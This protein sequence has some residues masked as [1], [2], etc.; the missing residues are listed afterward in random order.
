M[1]SH[2]RDAALAADAWC[3]H[4]EDSKRIRVLRVIARLNIGG[5][6][7]HATLLTERLD[8]SR[9]DSLLV[10]GTEEPSEGNYLELQG[11]SLDRLVVL[12]VLGREIR[13]L[14]DVIALGR[15]IALMRRGRP[16][17]VHTHTAKAGTLARLAAYLTGVPVILHTYHG[18]VF[19]GYF[20]PARTRVFLSIERWLAKCTDR[21]LTVSATV[22]ED[23]L[24]LRVGR[25]DQLEVVPLG[26][27]LGRFLDCEGLRGQLR[28]ELR[29]AE[30][31]PLVGIVARLVSIKAHEVFLQAAAELVRL[32]PQAHFVVVGDGERRAELAELTHRLGLSRRV[33]FLGWRQDLERI[34]ADLDL[35]VLTSRNEGSPVSLI[36]AMAAGRPVAATRV[37]GVPDLVEDGVTG[38]LVPPGDPAALT[39]AMHTLLADRDRRRVLGVAGRQRVAKTFTVERLL[40]DMERVYTQLLRRKL[41]WAP[42]GRDAAPMAAGEP[43]PGKEVSVI[44]VNWNVGPILVDCMRAVA[45][46]LTTVDGDCIVVDNGSAR[47]DMDPVRHEFPS[48][49]I[50]ANA[51][52]LGFA[53][54]ANQGI[55]ESRAPYVMLLNPD[56]FPMQG[57]LEHLVRFMDRHPEVAVVGPHITNTDG[58]AQGSARA[59]PGLWTAF[60]GRT[61]FLTRYFPRNPWSRRHIP[62][63]GARGDAPLAVDWVSGACMLIRRQAWEEIGGLDEAF[64]LYWEDADFCWRARNA[65]WEVVYD[66]RVSVIHSVGAS[67]RQ[68]PIRSTVAFHRTAYRLYRKHVTRSAWHPMNAVAMGGLLAHACAL[69]VSKTLVGRGR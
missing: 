12:P 36:E 63:L 10:A 55:R 5:P 2:H 53:R 13:G 6:A 26:L 61:S 52:N 11:K 59:F 50:I 42:F 41:G 31:V 4:P 16:H 62:V 64:F 45:K 65:G 28:A 66:P 18:H 60:F 54:A 8:P 20:S 48:V 43:A 68:A 34:Y 9:Y 37:G 22:R 24:K 3:S 33:H 56:A 27:D 17:I 21:L 29:L 30:N 57:T 15:L 67:S 14:H 69:I 39:N 46:E 25:G 47:G 35:V 1:S 58:T 40:G 32:A 23:L 7:V 51:R 19:R 44:V 38:A 49:P